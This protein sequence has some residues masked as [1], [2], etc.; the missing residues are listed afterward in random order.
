MAEHPEAVYRYVA[1]DVPPGTTAVVR[2]RLRP[3]ARYFSIAL[4]DRWLQTSIAAGPTYLS[5]RG[6]HTDADGGF[7]L[8]LAHAD[9]GVPWLD[10][11]AAPRGVLFERHLGGAPA[12]PSTLERRL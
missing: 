2:G 8:V 4:Y 12:T 3:D 10:V 9:P 1:Y 11:S 6:L 7:V 5:S